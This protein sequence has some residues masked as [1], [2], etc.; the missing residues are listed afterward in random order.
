VAAP[1][2]ELFWIDNHNKQQQPEEEED[3]EEPATIHRAAVTIPNKL[4]EGELRLTG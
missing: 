3:V 2:N 1:Q 4:V